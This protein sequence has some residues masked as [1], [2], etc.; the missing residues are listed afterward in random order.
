MNIDPV[1]DGD[2]LSEDKAPSALALF[3]NLELLSP[4]DHLPTPPQHVVRVHDLHIEAPAASVPLPLPMPVYIPHSFARRLG[5]ANGAPETRELLH[6]VSFTCLPGEVLAIIGGSGSGKTTALN[7]V[8]FRTA[9]L[10]QTSGTVTLEKVDSSAKL[11][12]RNI[13][14]FVGYVR[15]DDLLLPYLTVRETLSFSANLRLPASMTEEARKVI[16]E[17]TLAELGLNDVADVI[18][19]GAY[20]KGISGGER[21][22]LS[23]GCVLVTLPSVLVLDEP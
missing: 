10:R 14:T 12:K 18:V 6:G 22:R 17:Q 23:I 1:I 19:G 3:D 16:V 2:N 7:S 9:N 20:R 8:A 21:R 5:L 4:L 11:Y 15:Q 13:S